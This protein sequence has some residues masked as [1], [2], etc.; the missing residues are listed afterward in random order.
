MYAE[1]FNAVCVLHITEEEYRTYI[2]LVK[3]VI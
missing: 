1:V 2:T 3:N